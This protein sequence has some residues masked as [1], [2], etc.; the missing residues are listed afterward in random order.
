MPN[1]KFQITK[2]AFFLR[3]FTKSYS[4]STSSLF[5]LDFGASK[6]HL[7]VEIGDG[8]ALR[9]SKKYLQIPIRASP[10]FTVAEKK[11]ISDLSSYR[12]TLREHRFRM[13]QKC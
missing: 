12:S 9:F 10:L 1:K 7:N 8:C 6:L 11:W 13:L 4:E 2:M 5:S 3:S